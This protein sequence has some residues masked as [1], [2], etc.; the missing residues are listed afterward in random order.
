M[1]GPFNS[2]SIKNKTSVLIVGAGTS[3]LILALW[4]KKKGISFRIIDKNPAPI[5][6][7]G[8]EIIHARSLDFYEQLGIGEKILAVSENISSLH[9]HFNSR[10]RIMIDLADPG[11][12]LLPQNVHEKILLDQLN[13]SNVEIERGVEL[14]QFVQEKYQVKSIVN[15]PKGEEQISSAYLCGCDGTD[16]LIRRFLGVKFFKKGLR[17][18]FF[19]ADLAIKDILHSSSINIHLN[20]KNVF[21]SLPLEKAD[22][23]RVMGIVPHECENKENLSFINVSDQVA[24]GT[25]FHS[26]EAISFSV[27]KVDHKVSSHMHQGRTFLVGDA[28]HVHAPAFSQGMN[29]GIGD[30]VN[31]A[32]KLAAVL[33]GQASA[34]I[35]QTF[36]T[37]RTTFAEKLNMGADRFFH[38]VSARTLRAA[39]V[40]WI[41]LPLTLRLLQRSRWFIRFLFRFLTQEDLNYRESLLSVGTAGGLRSGDKLPWL[42]TETFDNYNCLK[43]MDWHIQIYGQTHSTFNS[44]ANFRGFKIYEFEW[45]KSAKALGFAKDAFYLVRPD[46]YIALCDLRQNAHILKSFLIE[47]DF[48]NTQNLKMKSLTDVALTDIQI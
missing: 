6:N 13:N 33:Q 29:A 16:S 12:L 41:F 30:A 26:N 20:R 42:K 38:F 43:L 15:G 28:A 2:M 37:E 9:F 18:D 27:K 40:R 19:I 23:V 14:I 32:W 17:Q 31:L 45:S 35:L 25:A 39:V 10:R 4:L 11:L 47:W 1:T 48:D 3:G 24:A 8:A 22:A 7:S 44:V 21:V 36:D 5:T 34:K 46:G